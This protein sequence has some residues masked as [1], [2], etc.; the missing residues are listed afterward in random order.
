M[1]PLNLEAM[2]IGDIKAIIG[3]MSIESANEYVEILKSDSRTACQKMAAQIEKKKVIYDRETERMEHIFEFEREALSQGYQYIA[4]MDEAGRGPLVGPVVAAAVIL[5]SNVDWRG[6]DDSKK[7]TSEQREFF[8]DKITQHA[9]AYGIGVASHIEIDEINILNATKL[10][11]KRA[12]ENMSLKAD[13]LL[14]DAVKLTDIDTI[15]VSLI[16]GDSRSASIA[17]ASIIAKVTRDRMLE[18]LHEKH[19]EYDFAKHK[20]Y[21]T[22]KHYDAI[23]KFGLIEEHR[24]SFLKDFI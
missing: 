7:L 10:A 17:A 12:L 6:I 15:Q 1:K 22:D 23:R 4:G 8:Y 24:R 5:N 20:G 2:A 14:I 16:K 19:P 11:M 3:Q 18:A 9:I 21:G 13:Y